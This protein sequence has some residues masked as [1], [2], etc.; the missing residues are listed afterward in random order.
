MLPPAGPIEAI[1]QTIWQQN[2]LFAFTTK[3]YMRS[4]SLLNG[5]AGASHINPKKNSFS[6]E[7]FLRIPEE[8]NGNS[9][10]FHSVHPN[11]NTGYA[12]F[13]DQSASTTSCNL[14]FAL[15]SGS[16]NYASASHSIQKGKW[17][18]LVFEYDNRTDQQ[19]LK[20]M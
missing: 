13:I 2:Y 4:Q 9:F 16:N 6:V 14:N 8:S 20:I 11:L 19:T 1:E 15:L 10:I 17:H 7:C 18:N 12:A 5:E 3:E